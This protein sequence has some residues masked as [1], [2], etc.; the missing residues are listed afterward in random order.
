MISILLSSV[1]FPDGIQQEIIEVVAGSHHSAA[2][3]GKLNYTCEVIYI[4]N[5]SLPVSSGY[6]PFTLHG[7]FGTAWIKL[8]PVSST[9]T[10]VWAMYIGSLSRNE[11]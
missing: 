8:V 11:N 7:I 2:L 9:F 1:L 6:L 3:T 5:T 4:C 10:H